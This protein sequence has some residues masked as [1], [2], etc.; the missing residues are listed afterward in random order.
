MKGWRGTLL[1]L[2]AWAGLS[3]LSLGRPWVGHGMGAILSA[4]LVVT[5]LRFEAGDPPRRAWLGMAIAQASVLVVHIVAMDGWPE[6]YTSW[7]IPVVLGVNIIWAGAMGIFVRNAY[8]SGLLPPW[9]LRGRLLT[10]VAV[11]AGLAALGVVL[12]EELGDISASSKAAGEMTEQVANSISGVADALMFIGAVFLVRMAAAMGGG[13]LMRMYVL[14]SLSAVGYVWI[15][16]LNS[17]N[18]ATGFTP[19]TAGTH[20]WLAFANGLLL[21]AAVAQMEVLKDA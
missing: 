7:T 2:A 19:L 6:D 20:L 18:N 9:T 10:G 4:V 8:G 16:L 5:A 15:D 13:R 3:V 11:L 14:L 17:M 12:N 1:L 21:A